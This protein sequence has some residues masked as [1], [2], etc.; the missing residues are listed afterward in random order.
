MNG[1]FAQENQTNTRSDNI[2]Y[3][4]FFSHMW[5]TC[6][7]HRSIIMFI[8]IPNTDTYID[9]EYTHMTITNAYRIFFRHNK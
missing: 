4:I 6:E 1:Q 2:N 8:Q 5:C 7:F 3:Q 9:K